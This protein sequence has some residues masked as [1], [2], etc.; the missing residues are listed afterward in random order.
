MLRMLLENQLK[1]MD[2]LGISDAVSKFS[3]ESVS[4]RD[5][6]SH[7]APLPDDELSRAEYENSIVAVNIISKNIR[8]RTWEWVQQQE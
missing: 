8:L 6:V 7:D 2:A 5:A 4:P 1:I 3:F